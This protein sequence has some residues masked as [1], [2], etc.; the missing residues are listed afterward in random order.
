MEIVGAY[1]NLPHY[2][3]DC[4]D[5]HASQ[6]PVIVPS[7]WG[8]QVAHRRSKEPTLTCVCEACVFLCTLTHFYQL[9]FG[10]NEAPR[11]I[12]KLEGEKRQTR[13]RAAARK[14]NGLPLRSQIWS[15]GCCSA[16]DLLAQHAWGP[17]SVSFLAPHWLSMAVT[18]CNP[19]TWKMDD[20]AAFKGVQD[21]THTLKPAFAYTR[22]PVRN[23]TKQNKA[24]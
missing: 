11:T 10:R 23:K 22:D 7:V 19:C 18:S 12:L 1:W 24:P 9:C 21:Y 14:I 17:G 13:E 4:G 2:T 20:E 6:V 15:R 8:I 16:G 3:N 5:L